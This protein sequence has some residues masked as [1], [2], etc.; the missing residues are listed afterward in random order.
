MQY[1]V[2]FAD[3][4]PIIQKIAEDILQQQGFEVK[5]VCDSET[6]L[7]ELISF[8]PHILV[9]DI[10]LRG[11]DGYCLCMEVKKRIGNPK[12]PVILLAGAYEPYDEEYAKFAEADEYILKPFD[13][14][15]LV[16]KIR[17]LLNFDYSALY[18]PPFYSDNAFSQQPEKTAISEISDKDEQFL[19]KQ[20]NRENIKK[21][22]SELIQAD[23]ITEKEINIP[24]QTAINES[25]SKIELSGQLEQ[26]ELRDLIIKSLDELIA[27]RF[28]TAISEKLS[29]SMRAQIRTVLYEVAPTIIEKILR[30]KINIVISSLMDE[31]QTEIKNVLPE[32]VETIIRRKFEKEI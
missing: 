10:S 19:I 24:H 7:K 12:I 30:E 20:G 13:S 11:L 31:I 9:A 15:E 28:K 3:E 22:S 23:E 29:S 32:I 17:K 18:E 14:L 8:K 21:D 16:G 4:S 5:T 2:L 27:H 25:C 6:A 1:R 26:D